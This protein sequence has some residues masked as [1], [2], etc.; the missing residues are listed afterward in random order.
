MSMSRLLVS[1]AFLLS[2]LG[3]DHDEEA[4]AHAALGND[5]VG[6]MLH[7]GA[8]PFQGRHFHAVVVVEMDMKRRHREIMMAMIVLHQASRQISRG[9]V[10]DIDKRGHATP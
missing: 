4:V 10:V 5:V 9:M 6:K 1:D 2:V 3:G 8:A 7:L